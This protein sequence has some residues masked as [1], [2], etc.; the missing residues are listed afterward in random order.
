MP[1]NGR[2]GV[3]AVVSPVPV[4][5]PARQPSASFGPVQFEEEVGEESLEFDSEGVAAAQLAS[6]WARNGL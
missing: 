4:V 6:R 5:F 2:G 3:R 1:P